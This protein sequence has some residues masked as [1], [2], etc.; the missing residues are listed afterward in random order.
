MTGVIC[1]L[2]MVSTWLPP[3]VLIF[4]TTMFSKE[5]LNPRV[6]A[7]VMRTMDATS[8]SCIPAAVICSS[9]SSIVPGSSR[10]SVHAD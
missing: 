6:K 9:V 1:S 3:S 4:A 7:C 2:S 8:S 10:A 5:P